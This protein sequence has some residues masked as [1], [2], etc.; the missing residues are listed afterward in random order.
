[1]EM[2]RAGSAFL[3]MARRSRVRHRPCGGRDKHK[4]NSTLKKKSVYQTFQLWR[5]KKTQAVIKS[6][7]SHK[8][9]FD[10]ALRDRDEGCGDSSL[11][12]K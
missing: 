12:P 4:G 10:A 8:V 6:S 11:T 3:K 2:G 5:G 1:M 9:G 7:G